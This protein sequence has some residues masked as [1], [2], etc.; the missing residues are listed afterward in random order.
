MQVKAL[1]SFDKLDACLHSAM[2]RRDYSSVWL[3][4]PVV[5]KQVVSISLISL[6]G[7][8]MAGCALVDLGEKK[9]GLGQTG[10]TQ[11]TGYINQVTLIQGLLVC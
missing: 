2:E 9:P 10:F 7:C 8:V 3:L 11:V 4:V 5:F 6:S 1:C